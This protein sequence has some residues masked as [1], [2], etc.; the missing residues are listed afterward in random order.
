VPTRIDLTGQKFG[1]LT[2]L[3]QA[4][5]NQGQH[6][7]RWVCECDCSPGKEQISHGYSLR[8]GL[9]QSCGCWQREKVSLPFG[10]S[11][12]NAVLGRYKH[13]AELCGREWALSDE[14]FDL[15]TQ[16]DCHYCGIGPSTIMARQRHHGSFTYNGID[17]MDN[18]VGYVPNN[19]VPCCKLCQYAKRNMPY[20]EFKAWL[21]R[22]GAYQLSFAEMVL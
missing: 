1:R 4:P 21:R 18:A 17:R 22:A 19:V 6:G 8:A 13:D 9:A 14:Q 15:L 3:R 11:Q 2:V 16:S 12:R 5:S 7:L 20:E 10:L